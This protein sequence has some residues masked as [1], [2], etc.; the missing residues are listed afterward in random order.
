MKTSNQ[1]QF[2]EGLNLVH[3]V[4]RIGLSLDMV[5]HLSVVL[6]SKNNI[7]TGNESIGN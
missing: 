4:A 5:V 7:Q 2:L 3:V 6:R 1:I